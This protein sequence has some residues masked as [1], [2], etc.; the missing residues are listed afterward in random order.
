MRSRVVVPETRRLEISDGDWLIVRKRLTHGE[1]SEAVKRR[2][3]TG[4]DGVGR[5]DPIQ[6]GH[7][8]IVAYLVDW[9]M[10]T[11]DGDKIEIR[12]QGPEYVDAALDSFDDDTVTEILAAIRTHETEMI[13]AREEEK[14]TIPSGAIASSPI[15]T[16]PAVAAGGTSGSVN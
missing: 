11:P 7:A 15:S 14:K 10:T 1:L 12:G 3:F 9:S 16:S 8:Q 5:V 2:F 4:A 13:A 6:M